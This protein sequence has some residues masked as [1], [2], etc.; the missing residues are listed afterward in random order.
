MRE[1]V[2]SQAPVVVKIGTSSLGDAAGGVDESSVRSVAGH[3][4][5]AWDR[6]HP[7]I[8]VSSGAIAAGVRVLQLEERPRDIQGLQV[9]AAV[10]QGRLMSMYTAV[11]DEL[12]LDVGQVLLTRDILARRN[13]YLHARATLD[14]MLSEGIVPIVNENDSVA[15]DEVRFGDNDTLAAIVSHLVNAGLLLLLTDTLGIHTDDPRLA[16][17]DLLPAIRHN[18]EILDRL[19]ESANMGSFGSGG[20]TTKIAAARMAAWG[21]IPTVIANAR[22]ADVAVRAISG[23]AVGTWIDPRKSTLSAR[24]LWIAFG[25]PSEGAIEVDDGAASALVVSGSSLLPAGISGVSG[26]FGS[27]DAVEITHRSEPIGK[28]VSLWDSDRI[29]SYRGQHSSTA[30]GVVMHRDDLVMFTDEE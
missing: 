30:G 16:E 10:G 24:K 22:E 6:G 27:G 11:F 12:G 5:A 2:N 20:V 18:D 23:E 25:L 4:A 21:G 17:A 7:T 13:Q 26:T 14:R 15:V 9:A 28:G 29:D 8:L 1:P 3:V 19:Q